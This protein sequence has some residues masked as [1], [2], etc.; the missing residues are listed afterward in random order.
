M[1]ICHDMQV[2]ILFRFYIKII[3]WKKWFSGSS[4]SSSLKYALFTN[5]FSSCIKNVFNLYVWK[6]VYNNYGTKHNLGYFKSKLKS[7]ISIKMQVCIVLGFLWNL[8]LQMYNLKS[9]TFIFLVAKRLTWFSINKS[10]SS[11]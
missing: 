4:C 9:S 10:G 8:L 1:L 5:Y 2:S 7:L 6:S 11:A 3:C